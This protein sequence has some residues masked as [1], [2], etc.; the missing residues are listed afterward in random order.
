MSTANRSHPPQIPSPPLT[1]AGFMQ[2]PTSGQRPTAED[3]LK[4]PD[5]A[6]TSHTV[7]CSLL[8]TSALEHGTVP[9]PAGEPR[10]RRPPASRQAPPPRSLRGAPLPQPVPGPRPEAENRQMP[11]QSTSAA[12]TRGNP[13]RTPA[14]GLRPGGE[15]ARNPPKHPARGQLQTPAAHT[16]GNP[17][18]RENAAQEPALGPQLAG[19]SPPP[20]PD[21]P[22]PWHRLRDAYLRATILLYET[23][24]APAAKPRLAATPTGL[25]NNNPRGDPNTA[26]RCGARTRAGTPCRSPAM[27]NGRCRMHGGRSTGPRTLDGLNRL[28]AATTK[29]G[30]YATSAARRLHDPDDPFARQS[31]R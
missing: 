2:P 1:H 4:I 3:A 17:M 16:R 27:P 8:T 26:P 13:M 10:Q 15:N 7:R 20:P 21:H 9:V 6:N 22:I 12:E 24:R 19:Q 5:L 29:H 31:L 25:R 30:A 23:L 18:Q 11:R 14:P 28:R